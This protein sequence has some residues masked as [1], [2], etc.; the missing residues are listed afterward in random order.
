M[1]SYYD[2][3]EHHGI[4]GQKWGV[5]RYQNE[6]G[7]LT[8]DGQIRYN[9]NQ[10]S[11]RVKMKKAAVGTGNFVKKR[12]QQK[13][14]E[15][16]GK[17]PAAGLTDAELNE[18]LVRMRKEAEYSRLQREINGTNQNQG[19]GKKGDKK[20]PL[21]SKALTMPIAT[22]IGVGV[23]AISKEKV[24]AFMEHRAGRKLS[25]FMRAAKDSTSERTLGKLFEGARR[26]ADSAGNPIKGGVNIKDIVQSNM[27]KQASNITL[28]NDRK[29]QVGN[30]IKR[31]SL[32]TPVLKRRMGRLNQYL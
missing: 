15:R 26:A 27:A 21:L 31:T 11:F 25:S 16:R 29:V 32:N 30:F 14:D 24:T 2:Y 1:N 6:D 3:L 22:A 18:R 19:G 12:V 20:H 28:N 17:S 9:K 8:T 7:T 10:S 4:K 5:R 13:I 23:A